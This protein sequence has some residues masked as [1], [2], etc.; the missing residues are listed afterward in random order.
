MWKPNASRLSYNLVVIINFKLQWLVIQLTI[1]FS[2]VL[3]VSSLGLTVSLK[4]ANVSE[5]KAI[6]I[7]SRVLSCTNIP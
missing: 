1:F 2:L 7:I 4:I 6:G 3:Y 5:F